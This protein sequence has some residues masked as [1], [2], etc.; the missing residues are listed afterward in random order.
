MTTGWNIF[1]K[2]ILS[3]NPGTFQERSREAASGWNGLSDLEKDRYNRIAEEQNK[4][5]SLDKLK[6]TLKKCI[7]V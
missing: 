1:S 7:Q 4:E 5:A 3:Q 2:P 6:N